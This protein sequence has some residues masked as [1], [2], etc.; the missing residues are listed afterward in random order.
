MSNHVMNF[1]FELNLMIDWFVY[2]IEILNNYCSNNPN[3][4]RN[5]ASCSSVQGGGFVCVCTA[6][7]TG[8]LCDYPTGELNSIE[9]FL[10]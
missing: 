5:G 6:G 8:N 2:W 1:S 3:P 4:C 10:F 7:Y 9:K